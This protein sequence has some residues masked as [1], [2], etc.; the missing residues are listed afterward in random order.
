MRARRHNQVSGFCGSS[1]SQQSSTSELGSLFRQSSSTTINNI[2]APVFGELA[3]LL[4]L[5][6]R[7]PG[8]RSKTQRREYGLLSD[9]V[10]VR[11]LDGDVKGT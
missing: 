2:F 3:Q 4:G 7:L 6:A 11:P 5:V 9:R 1:N 8:N 10:P